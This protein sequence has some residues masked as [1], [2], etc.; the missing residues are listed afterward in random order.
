MKRKATGGAMAHAAAVAMAAVA[1]LA[2]AVCAEER[3][4]TF[5]KRIPLERAKAIVVKN[6]RGDIRIVGD[7]KAGEIFCAYVK[8]V[9]GRKREDV[10]R[11]FNALSL[12]VER[13]GDTIVIEAVYPKRSEGEWGLL[14]LITQ[15]YASMSIEMDMTVPAGVAVAVTTGS[16][17][18]DLSEI[19]GVVEVA[20][21]SGDVEVSRVGGDIEIQVASGGIDAADIA[22]AAELATASGDVSARRIGKS[23]V[24]RSASGDIEVADVK[25]DLVIAGTS[26]DVEVENVG[27]LEFSGTSG[28]ASFRGVRGDVAASTSTGD[29]TLVAA[30]DGQASIE[31]VTSS[32][33]IS[34]EFE[35]MIAGGFALKAQTTSGEI[36]V[37]LPIKL[38]KVGRHYLAGVVGDGKSLVVVETSSGDISVTGPED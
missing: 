30:P 13:S 24:V 23:A 8:E 7:K 1:V 6:A 4:E 19:D 34:L 10:E 11:I 9:R 12:E 16:G 29:V 2:A 18:V 25:G 21:A 20:T 22:G 15:R 26:G 36:A 35:K 28:N 33:D 31:I 5:E 3:T 27:S 38:H 17:D 14:S 32:G 37:T